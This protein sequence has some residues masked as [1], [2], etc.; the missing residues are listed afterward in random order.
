MNRDLL[1]IIDYDGTVIGCRLIPCGTNLHTLQANYDML[2][3]QMHSALASHGAQGTDEQD[4]GFCLIEALKNSVM[5]GPQGRSEITGKVYIGDEGVCIYVSDA[6]SFYK[7]EDVKHCIEE[8]LD[9]PMLSRD[10]GYENRHNNYHC[11]GI[12]L[13]E[14]RKLADAMY[15]DTEENAICIVKAFGQNQN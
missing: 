5:H 14:I 1:D 15:V 4:I 3:M 2:R 12:G 6:G 9:Q 11:D 7:R 10:S 13:L 8:T